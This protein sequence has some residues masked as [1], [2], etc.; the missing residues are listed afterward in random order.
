M[1]KLF[2]EEGGSKRAFRIGSGV[3]TVGSGA[4]ARLRLSST[5]VAELHFELDV[6]ADGVR[7]R[8]RPGVVP[9][10]VG[11]RAAVNE[12]L[13]AP[14]ARVEL[15][16][17]SLWFEVEGEAAAS[18]AAPDAPAPRPSAPARTPHSAAASERLARRRAEPRPGRLPTWLVP[19]L[20][21]ASAGIVFL[22]WL[23]VMK[24][25]ASDEGL[26]QNKLRAAQQALAQSDYPAARA[27]LAAIPA[28]ALTPELVARKDALAA[29]IERADAAS[30]LVLENSAGS[31]FFDTLLKKYEG[32]HLQGTPEPAKVRLFLERCRTFRE[33]WPRHPELDWVARQERR[34]EG[35]VDLG[36]PRT[37]ADVS[38]AV[39]DL[40]D[41][42]P[43]NYAAAFAM[44]DE[45]LERVSGKE[46]LGARNLKREL[47]EQR[48]EYAKDRLEQARYEF[49]KK[50][51]PNK[52]VW[53]LVHN[54]AWLGDEALANESARYLVRMPDLA[55]H[56][57]GY[58]RNYPDR[59]AAVMANAIVAGW[60]K[61]NDF[62]P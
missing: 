29:E 49:D 46:E 53:W 34:F 50:Q 43:R 37:W 62:A 48:V 57:L 17:A 25:G 14:R 7:L 58:K 19:L 39:A 59:Y 1:L 44:L 32:I 6:G 36:A 61:E 15:G 22:I 4:E 52:A 45:L 27:E 56:L 5:G 24:S 18:P 13:L 21:L 9:P 60:A 38:W 41:T 47:V 51:D 2:V 3:L 10:R 16:G 26:A 8:L 20:V 55:G 12:S 40:T 54:V 31:R 33:R 23:R 28:T 11:G 42:S 35:A 30:A